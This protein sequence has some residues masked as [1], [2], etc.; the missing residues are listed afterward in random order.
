[1]KKNI[2]LF[3]SFQRYDWETEGRIVARDYP[4][5]QED[6]ET[7]LIYE[8]DIVADVPDDFDPRAGIIA[9]LESKKQKAK[10]DYQMLMNTLDG[11]IQQLRAITHVPDDLTHNE[12]RG[13]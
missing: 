11:K 1:M 13:E 6:H 10:A 3:I 12:T 5:N 7:Q 8:M 2:H 9:A 4:P